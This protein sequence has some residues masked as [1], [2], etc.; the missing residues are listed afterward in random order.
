MIVNPVRYGNS[1]METTPVTITANGP[2]TVYWTDKDGKYAE[3]SYNM[4]N[5]GSGFRENVLA[6]SFLMTYG[7]IASFSGVARKM[8]YEGFLIS[9]FQV[10]S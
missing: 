5:Y 8:D 6:G 3:K 10:N 1:K 9:A 4:I 2:F 7:N